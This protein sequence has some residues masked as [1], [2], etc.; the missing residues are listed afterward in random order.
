MND[1]PKLRPGE[2][3][4]AYMHGWHDGAGVKPIRAELSEHPRQGPLYLAGY[5][6]GRDAGKDAAGNA[7]ERFG[8]QPAILKPR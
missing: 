8:Y 3:Y 5:K 2:Q 7:A 6:D 1:E 4:H